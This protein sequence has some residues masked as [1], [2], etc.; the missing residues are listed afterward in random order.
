MAR[1][2]TT[3]PSSKRREAKRRGS[4]RQSGLSALVSEAVAKKLNEVAESKSGRTY[5]ELIAE[6][7]VKDAL[8]GKLPSQVIS[9]LFEN[10]DEGKGSD[11]HKPLMERS[12]HELKYFIKHGCWP[13]RE[14]AGRDKGL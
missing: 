3:S 4:G 9:R 5:G 8:S 13:R 14:R 11:E 6:R 7:L 2:R 12:N 10:A 1:R